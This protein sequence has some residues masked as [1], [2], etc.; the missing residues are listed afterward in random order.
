[1]WGHFTRSIVKITKRRSRGTAKPNRCCRV[2]SPSGVLADPGTHGEMFVSMGVSYW[3]TGNH[4][5]AIQLTEQG[6]DVLQRSV[7]DGTLKPESLAIPYGN[8]SDDAP[9]DG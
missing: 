3:D 7:V 1:M 9:K 4:Q 2:K 8:H 5:L 6:T